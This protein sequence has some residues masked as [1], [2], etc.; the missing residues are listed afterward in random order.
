MTLMCDNVAINCSYYL[1]SCLSW[2]D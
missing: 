1:K 2:K